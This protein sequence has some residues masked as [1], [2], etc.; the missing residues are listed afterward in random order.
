MNR[1]EEIWINK[2]PDSEPSG[3]TPQ[4][5]REESAASSISLGDTHIWREVGDANV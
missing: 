5:G 3:S 2:A 4:L 1:L